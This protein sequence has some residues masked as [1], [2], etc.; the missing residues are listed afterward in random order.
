MATVGRQRQPTRP[1]GAIAEAPEKY[2]RQGRTVA[3]TQFIDEHIETAVASH[4]LTYSKHVLDRDSFV[5]IK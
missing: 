2:S 1:L 5:L 4:Y 3:Y